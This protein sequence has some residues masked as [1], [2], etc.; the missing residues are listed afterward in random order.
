ME[1]WTQYERNF[2]ENAVKLKHEQKNI[3]DL[4]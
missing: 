1:K 4:A 2:K 3:S